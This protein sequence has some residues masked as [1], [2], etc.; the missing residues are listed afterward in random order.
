MRSLAA[1]LTLAHPVH[2][3][4]Q[5]TAMTTRRTP[6]GKVKKGSRWKPLLITLFTLVTL[7][8]LFTLFKELFKEVPPPRPTSC[9]PTARVSA[10]GG[11]WTPARPRSA[12]PCACA[13]RGRRLGSQLP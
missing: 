3:R 11:R 5:A 2:V 13:R 7:I 12:A 9:P 8:T 10:L 1:V 6:A 4:M